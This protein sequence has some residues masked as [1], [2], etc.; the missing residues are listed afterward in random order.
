MNLSRVT[1]AAAA[2]LPLISSLLAAAFVSTAAEAQPP[3]A[4]EG[5]SQVNPYPKVG[6]NTQNRGRA[7]DDKYWGITDA[8]FLWNQ[9]PMARIQNQNGNESVGFSSWSFPQA[10]NDGPGGDGRRINLY[11]APLSTFV[12]P[13]ITLDDI[14]PPATGPGVAVLPLTPS[15]LPAVPGA[16]NAGTG[17]VSLPPLGVVSANATGGT[18]SRTPAVPRPTA[19]AADYIAANPNATFTWYPNIP[20]DAGVVRRYAIRVILPNIVDETTEARVSDARYTVFYS[21]RDRAGIIQNRSKVCFVSQSSDSSATAKYLSDTPGGAPAYF[22]FFSE[23]SYGTAVGPPQRARVV[24]DNTTADDQT[25]DAAG[26]PN[27]FV[28]ADALQFEQRVATVTA[29]PTLTP[30]NSGRGRKLDAVAVA[31]RRQ[32]ET[33]PNYRIGNDGIVTPV[34][35]GVYMPNS[36][37]GANGFTGNPT[38]PASTPNDFSVLFMGP[39][40]YARPKILPDEFNGQYPFARVI[41]TYPPIVQVASPREFDPITGLETGNRVVPDIVPVPPTV[42]PADVNESVGTR[43]RLDPANGIVAGGLPPIPIQAVSANNFQVYRPN[44]NAAPNYNLL[45]PDPAA[46]KPTPLFS[47]VQ[48]IMARTVYVPDPETGVSNSN[49][50]GTKTIEVGEVLGLD[51]QTGAVIWRFPDRTYLPQRRPGLELRNRFNG[52]LVP[53]AGSRNPIIGYEKRPVYA[54]NTIASYVDVLQRPINQIPGIE[55]YDVNENGVIDDTEVFIAPQGDNTSA[56]MG[57]SVT[58]AGQIP[59]FGDV[60]VPIYKPDYRVL[61]PFSATAAAV[62]TGLATSIVPDGGLLTV[63]PAPAGRYKT[64]ASGPVLTTLAYVASNNGVVYAF[65]P[66]GNN[67]NAYT[68]QEY[69]AATNTAGPRRLGRSR[70]GTTNVLWTFNANSLPRLRSG[71]YVSN[72]PDATV[73]QNE[74][75]EQYNKRL[76]GEVPATLGFGGASPVISYRKDENDTT[77][78][79]LTEEPRLFIGNQNGVMYALDA[80]AISIPSGGT[81][82]SLPFH[83]GEQP[84]NTFYATPV[85]VGAVA[86]IPADVRY[87]LDL[88]WWFETEAQS[89]LGGGAI[90]APAAVS[91]NR[92]IAGPPS[93]NTVTPP[94]TEKGVYFTS[95]AGRVYCVDWTGPVSKEYNAAALPI[96]GHDISFNWSGTDPSAVNGQPGFPVAPISADVNVAFVPSSTINDNYRFHNQ[97]AATSL[98]R[99]DNT[100]GKVRPRWVYPSQYVDIRG[101][102]YQT[103]TQ[104]RDNVE[105]VVGAIPYQAPA[106]AP[107]YGAPTLIDFPWT[108]PTT[109]QT[110]IRHFVA[111]AANDRGD[112]DT[113][114]ATGKV[115]LLDQAGDR[116][117][118]LTNPQGFGGGTRRAYSSPLDQYAVINE[119]LGRA[120]PVWTYRFQYGTYDASGNLVIQNPGNPTLSLNHGTE[121]RNTP[122]YDGDD[123][124]V[125]NAQPSRRITPTLFFGSTG[126]MYAIDFDL[127]TGLFTRWRAGT[128]LGSQ[129]VP[130]PISGGAVRTELIPDNILASNPN[131]EL[132]D[133]Q[134]PDLVT[135]PVGNLRFR[136]ILARTVPLFS[137]PSPVDGNIT[138]SGGPLQTRDSNVTGGVVTAVNTSPTKPTNDPPVLSPPGV[139]IDVTAVAARFQTSPGSD[140][141]LA[142]DRRVNQ[143]I[144]DPLATTRGSRT[145]EFLDATLGQ[146]IEPDPVRDRS[147]QF[148]TLFV[149]TGGASNGVN[150]VASGGLYQIS[151][152]LDGED[153]DT[154]T[155]VPT[156]D[157]G[158]LPAQTSARG[159]G[160]TTDLL[161]FNNSGHV[162]QIALS[163]PGGVGSGVSVLTPAYF[164]GT[165]PSLAAY[166]NGE[167]HTAGQ[168]ASPLITVEGFGGVLQPF[169]VT[170]TTAN[171]GQ[172]GLPLDANGL[173]FDKNVAIRRVNLVAGDP[174]DPAEPY[175]PTRWRWGG[176][177]V[178]PTDPTDD[179]G[180]ISLPGYSTPA[181]RAATTIDDPVFANELADGIRPD[182]GRYGSTDPLLPDIQN[183]DDFNPTAQNAVWIFAGSPD[184]ALNA[185]TPALPIRFGG[186]GGSGFGVGL[187]IADNN[188]PFANGQPKIDILDPTGPNFAAIV[189]GNQR[190]NRA[191]DTVVARGGSNFYEWGET[192]YIAVFDVAKTGPPRSRRNPFTRTPSQNVTIEIADNNGRA[193]QTLTGRMGGL[194]Y[195]PQDSYFPGSTA[196]I[197]SS[198]TDYPTLGVAVIPYRLTQGSSQTPG[199]IL[200][201]RLSP[202]SLN[203]ITLNFRTGTRTAQAVIPGGANDAQ[204]LENADVPFQIANPLA[205]L[206]FIKD[207]RGFP[208]LPAGAN[209]N[210]TANSIGPF[211]SSAAAKTRVATAANAATN[212]PDNTNA[213]YSQALANGNDIRRYAIAPYTQTGG[214]IRPVRNIGRRISP[215]DPTFHINVVAGIGI[216]DH[217]KTAS[218]DAENG[219]R[220]LRIANRSLLANLRGVRV[221]VRDDILWRTW[222]GNIPNDD[223]TDG[224]ATLPDGTPTAP[225]GS[226]PRLTPVAT[227]GGYAMRPDGIINFLPWEQPVPEVQPWKRSTIG[228][229]TTGAGGNSSQD[230]PDI[231]ARAQGALDNQVVSVNVNGVDLAAGQGSLAA[232][233]AS[234]TTPPIIGNQPNIVPTSNGTI[235]EPLLK[236]PYSVVVPGLNTS[237]P[238]SIFR[239]SAASLNVKI[240]KFQPANLVAIHSVTS[241]Y[242]GP[243]ASNNDD[244]TNPTQVPTS[245]GAVQLPQLAAD[246]RI[247]ALDPNTGL[248]T[249]AQDIAPF[250]YTTRLRVYIDSDNDGL[251]DDNEAFRDV[252]TWMGVGVDQSL[253]ANEKTPV[254]VTGPTG[255]LAMGFGMQNGFLGYGQGAN[256][257]QQG[258][259][260]SPLFNTATFQDSPY[261][262]FFASFAVKNSGNVNMWNLRAAQKASI[263][264]LG[265][266]TSF[267]QLRSTTVDPLMGIFAFGA[268]PALGTGVMPQIVTS[269]DA[270]LDS[271]WDAFFGAA[272]PTNALQNIV[273]PTATPTRTIYQQYYAGFGGKHTLHKPKVGD[274]VDSGTLLSIPDVPSSQPL[275]TNLSVNL[276]PAVPVISVAVPIGTP[277]G[278][279]GPVDT[280]PADFYVFEDHDTVLPYTAVPL[281]NGNTISPAGPLYAGQNLLHPGSASM[282]P[283]TGNGILRPRTAA[284][285]TANAET[286]PRTDPGIRIKVKVVEGAMTGQIADQA[287]GTPATTAVTTG[288]L[289]FID[290]QP[291][292]DVPDASGQRR[293]A[294]ALSPAAYRDANGSMHVFFARNATPLTATGTTG[295]GQPYNLF[296]SSLL[297]N[298]ATGQW[299]AAL[300]GA[301]PLALSYNA[302]AAPAGQWFTTPAQIP[303]GAANSSSTSP[304]V[305]QQTAGTQDAS[306]F[307][308][309]TYAG[310]NGAPI[311]NIYAASLTPAAGGNVA[312][313]PANPVLFNA[314]TSLQ[315]FGPRAAYDDVSNTTFVMYYGG[316]G[317]KWTLYYVATQAGVGGLPTVAGAGSNRRERALSLPLSITTASDPV[318]VIRT[319]R[320]RVTNTDFR[321][322][323]L[324]YTATARTDSGPNIYMTRYRIQA[325]P[326][327]GD[328]ARLNALPLVPRTREQLAATTG[329]GL[330]KARDIAWVRDGNPT[331]LPQIFINGAQITD[332]DPATGLPLTT[333]TRWAYDDTTNLLYQKFQR[334]GLGVTFVYVDTSAGTVRFRGTSGPTGTQVVSASYVPQT[335]RL[336]LDG[337]A[338]TAVTGFFDDRA[339]L[340]SATENALIQQRPVPIIAANPP[341]DYIIRRPSNTLVAGRT[342][343][344]WNQSAKG[345]GAAGLK[346]L[347]RRVG[348]DLKTGAISGARDNGSGNLVPIPPGSPSL[349]PRSDN[350]ESI[351]LTPSGLGP[352]GRDN[353]VQEPRVV[354]VLVDG[355]EQRTNCEIDAANGRIYVDPRLEGHKVTINYFA[356]PGGTGAPIPCTAVYDLAQ[357]SDLDPSIPSSTF[358]GKG[359]PMQRSIN[360][361]QPYAFLDRFDPRTTTTGRTADAPN[362]VFDPITQPGRVWLFWTSP[363]GRTGVLRDGTSNINA[364][365]FD[366]YWQTLA[367][368]FDFS[369]YKP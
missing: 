279:Y 297:W 332:I 18:Y 180:Q 97:R 206:A 21:F 357:I 168:F 132:T 89:E 290:P 296:Q 145:P 124:K 109:A 321:V 22:P 309:N 301:G 305:L 330:Y 292:L 62:T 166:V 235:G 275:S 61:P 113:A 192:V 93:A 174:T 44:A 43:L 331:L 185:F 255:G 182:Y 186:D 28:L 51:W 169:G 151:T 335:Y 218:S 203:N 90:S 195:A 341:R 29:T 190:P 149:T 304:F 319:I 161:R 210:R 177:N 34:A 167:P 91:T 241:T 248:P 98:A 38:D 262:P 308:L 231:L 65:D 243:N 88:K 16:T 39:E 254:E 106:T 160:F 179:D 31:P 238:Q 60:V 100:E 318:P 104:A 122:D 117:D 5:Q 294:A 142:T 115:Y 232:N 159:W 333:G 59:V 105:S 200:R 252:E 187:P 295:A 172:V 45:D 228:N 48:V 364:N 344:V 135:T 123:T 220:Y 41:G 154:I 351:A 280:A 288:I 10:V 356:Q 300:P 68:E 358:T 26:A 146:T 36:A 337:A 141:L 64:A 17:W 199:T 239:Q 19:A 47:Q 348:V 129:P 7:S 219:R 127:A 164:P 184:G 369:S 94:L 277:S 307:F 312:V 362:P 264:S 226:N 23:A 126:R 107:I 125:A 54:G 33:G 175:D 347:T 157:F 40:S 66:Y 303:A 256:A 204:I 215:N 3:V 74:S 233:I 313:G 326:G 138:I 143:E 83:K 246:R 324:Y 46:N 359:V 92:V 360:E 133:W 225:G 327:R 194:G 287:A 224:G 306:L 244:P 253:S 242:L 276:T 272:T 329:S 198:P 85:A 278:T 365:G 268:D 52:S 134:N 247:S 289:P 6:G 189:A 95:A 58:L 271:S 32:P 1:S 119:P 178:L 152:N 140:P 286:L 299:Q 37:Y 245:G 73:R 368:F 155:N 150:P 209:A 183:N 158:T 229:G 14:V 27:Q 367:P 352:D 53:F 346:M 340:D 213:Q 234:F 205:L 153:A 4:T 208:T 80:S 285:A 258:L 42:L 191:T 269:L 350:P 236:N 317:G 171:T 11:G 63:A 282:L 212:L 196:P 197:G 137:D 314:D 13:G 273:D 240:P 211:E 316:V 214:S 165:D 249:G 114:P 72:P 267:Y 181:I 108:N 261:K 339:L 102:G 188:N 57:S 96:I 323:D 230:Y 201:A 270:N 237:V 366:I 173:Y 144:D 251:Y 148:P 310:T 265:A 76:Y 50:D 103:P 334:P 354:S 99:P 257:F 25:T 338:S 55:G 302:A 176:R 353:R 121:V 86:N 118:F 116:R 87:R 193:V 24:L 75:V 259:L 81:I 293:P 69:D 320:E 325:I 163:G 260:P 170:A 281:L 8:N 101:A 328:E 111:V 202:N 49:L 315:R 266:P 363:R 56:G 223:A 227:N 9:T 120:A 78:N 35:G 298:T 311:R 274:P 84:A 207:T 71:Q 147:F 284:T 15:L 221:Q 139:G 30:I 77:I 217:G 250:G 20:G 79:R 2:L 136:P 70:P 67:D 291:L 112:G 349:S 336:T 216:G 110:V 156:S 12:N 162:F 130:L 361:N 82:P 263:S 283:I 222:P 345:A 343:L 342:W 128:G 131:E 355:V 322:M